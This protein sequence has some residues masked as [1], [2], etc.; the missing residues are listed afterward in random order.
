MEIKERTEVALQY[1]PLIKY[2]YLFRLVTVDDAEFILKL[3]NDPSLS[4]YLSQTSNLLFDQIEWIRNYKE[5][6]KKG[7]EF[8]I[9]S[10]DVTTN[11]KLGV[12]RI[13]NITN[14]EFEIGS[15]LYEPGHEISASIIGDLVAR[16]F[17]F[18]IF[19][20]PSCVFN[21]RKEN[22]NVLRYHLAFKPD[23]IKEDEKNIYFRLIVENFI[24]H[25]NKLIKI[26]GHE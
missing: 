6:E 19:N 16:S 15:W 3:R 5:R 21:V 22:K 23:V 9:I 24:I 13:Y 20:F 10:I 4:A 1:F 7:I 11:K 12:N 26:L 25:K 2:G 18:E 14:N 8:Y 17:A